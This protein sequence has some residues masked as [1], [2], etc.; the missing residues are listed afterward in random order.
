MTNKT[1]ITSDSPEQLL[2][3]AAADFATLHAA[4][5]EAKDT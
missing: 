2:A 3:R 1:V 4:T 5:L